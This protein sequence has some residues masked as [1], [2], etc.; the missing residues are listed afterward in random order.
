MP[1]QPSGGGIGRGGYPGIHAEGV[2]GPGWPPSEKIA[3]FGAFVV[4]RP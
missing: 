2:G 4:A 1:A 3:L